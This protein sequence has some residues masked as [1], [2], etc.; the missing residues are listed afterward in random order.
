MP[1]YESSLPHPVRDIEN[2]WITLSDGCRLAARLWLP[3]DA[4]L[5]PVPATL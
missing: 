4:D 1:V 5:G 3:D 2:V